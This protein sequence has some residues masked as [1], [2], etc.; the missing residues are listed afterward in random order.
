MNSADRPEPSAG[1]LRR[2]LLASAVRRVMVAG[3]AAGPPAGALGALP[4][5][6]APDL[7]AEAAGKPPAGNPESRR[8]G[9]GEPPA[10]Q[11]PRRAPSAEQIAY[12]TSVNSVSV[13][14]LR[15][16]DIV[17]HN[18]HATRSGVPA[19]RGLAGPGSGQPGSGQPGSGQPGSGEA[20]LEGAHGA[21]LCGR[22]G[23]TGL[24]PRRPALPISR[25]APRPLYRRGW[26]AAGRHAIY[27]KIASPGDRESCTAKAYSHFPAIC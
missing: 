26:H 9:P 8:R 3:A 15:L 12:A 22:R 7:S 23:A 5:G 6:S 17:R 27:V 13:S 24:L 16:S 21:A 11:S 25:P 10:G 1:A 19:A 20:F 14:I 4:A 18:R 2:A